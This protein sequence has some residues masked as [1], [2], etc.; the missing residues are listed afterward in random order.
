M[1]TKGSG[2]PKYLRVPAATMSAELPVTELA[3]EDTNIQADNRPP[4]WHPEDKVELNVQDFL[5]FVQS[6]KELDFRAIPKPPTNFFIQ[7]LSLNGKTTKENCVTFDCTFEILVLVDAWT[8]CDLLDSSITVHSYKTS[9]TKDAAP[10]VSIDFLIASFTLFLFV[11]SFFPCLFCL[12]FSNL[13]LVFSFFLYFFSIIPSSSLQMAI[14]SITRP[15]REA[16]R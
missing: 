14:G 7:K 10:K 3:N 1:T 15:K 8:K 12:L 11:S 5:E 16:T 13:V 2:Q 9:Y 4:K 6:Y